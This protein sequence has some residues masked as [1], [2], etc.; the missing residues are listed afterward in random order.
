MTAYCLK[1]PRESGYEEVMVQ[2]LDFRPE[3]IKFRK[4]N[5]SSPGQKQT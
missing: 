4:E 2:D 1:M 5:Y 3:N